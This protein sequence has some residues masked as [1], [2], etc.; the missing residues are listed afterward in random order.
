MRQVYLDSSVL[1]AAVSIIV[2]A[3]IE[4]SLVTAVPARV[5]ACWPYLG[6]ALLRISGKIEAVKHWRSLSQQYT[7]AATIQTPAHRQR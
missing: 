5:V 4:K 3:A 7:T 6:P 2:P 1:C